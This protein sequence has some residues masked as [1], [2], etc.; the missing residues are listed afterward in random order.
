MLSAST[1]PA[2]A[3]FILQGLSL[4]VISASLLFRWR[5]LER[6]VGLIAVSAGESVVPVP[7]L[8]AARAVNSKLQRVAADR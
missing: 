1:E 3:S 7:E 4:Q 5:K 8:A 6:E 2:V